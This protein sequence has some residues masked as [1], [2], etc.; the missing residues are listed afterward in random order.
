LWTTVTPST[1]S[2]LPAQ[3]D[4]RG[5]QSAA[6]NDRRIRAEIDRVPVFMF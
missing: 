1:F 3:P 2:I 5:R 4:S 6:I